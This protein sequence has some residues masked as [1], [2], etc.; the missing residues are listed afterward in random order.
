M[1]LDF[2][3]ALADY[4]AAITAKPTLYQAW[5][6]RGE[7]QM[8]LGFYDLAIKDFS[9]AIALKT[10]FNLSFYNIGLC[11]L[12]LKKYSEALQYIEK[13]CLADTS[14]KGNIALAEC[15]FYA[16]KNN[17]AVK[18]FNLALS[19]M[20]DSIGLLLGRGLAYYQLGNGLACKGDLT[21]YV[22]KG[23]VN[24]VACRQLGLT[25]LRMADTLSALDS[26]V[27]FL[28]Q[29]KAKV[30]V[31]DP[32]ASKALLFA[33]LTRGK[34]LMRADKEI[35]AMADFSKVIELDVANAEAYF[36][37]GKIMISL[38]QNIEGCLD[39]QNALKNGH[40]NAKK[41][42]ALYCGDDL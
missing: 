13:A 20:P 34:M 32:E 18:H 8:N 9:Q 27:V 21:N 15:Y 7:C 36:Q 4:S 39:L 14:I 40:V 3:G 24:A 1:A 23:G 33:Y 5:Q 17:L 41:L 38:G 28:E 2:A 19:T 22:N 10:D 11:Y 30:S 26:S 29:Y 35:E 25:Y 37:R 16:G 42:I 6:N 12:K 31:L